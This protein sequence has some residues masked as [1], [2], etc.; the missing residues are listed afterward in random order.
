MCVCCGV[1][2]CVRGGS[3]DSQG[4]TLFKGQEGWM[5]G[6]RGV[7]KR[8]GPRGVSSTSEAPYERQTI[9]NLFVRPGKTCRS[10]FIHGLPFRRG[11]DFSQ[12]SITVTMARLIW[13]PS[14]QRGV[15]TGEKCVKT[16][17]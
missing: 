9:S 7:E 2:V 3:L 4:A 5:G 14:R 16:I 15:R 1:G 11:R 13:G 10:A 17:H 8:G 12:T 6:W